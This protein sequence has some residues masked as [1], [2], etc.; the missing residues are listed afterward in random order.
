MLYLLHAAEH[1][2]YPRPT[3]TLAEGRLF[4]HKRVRSTPRAGSCSTWEYLPKL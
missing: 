1:W 3:H 2:L 4:A